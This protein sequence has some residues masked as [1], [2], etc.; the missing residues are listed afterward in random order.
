MWPIL[1]ETCNLMSVCVF[2][3]GVR[4]LRNERKRNNFSLRSPGG[5]DT[6]D[7]KIVAPLLHSTVSHSSGQDFDVE[8]GHG[9]S[10]LSSQKYSVGSSHCHTQ[11]NPIR[12]LA[13]AGTRQQGKF[14]GCN[15]LGLNRHVM[16]YYNMQ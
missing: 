16:L 10:N 3:Y 4:G 12:L 8:G 2:P 13:F 15:L 14:I 11:Y 9:S 6:G 1:F 7:T 5:L